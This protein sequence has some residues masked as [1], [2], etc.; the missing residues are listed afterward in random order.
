M[1]L[2]IFFGILG[3]TD[4]ITTEY[5]I[6]KDITKEVNPLMKN[7]WV[8]WG[9]HTFKLSIPFILSYIKNQYPKYNIP[10]DILFLFLIGIYSIVNISNFYQL[11]KYFRDEGI[12]FSEIER[13]IKEKFNLP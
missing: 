10:I 5:S 1:I 4:V 3:I 6:K 9:G 13:K 8:R 7:K 12:D 2:P 11:S